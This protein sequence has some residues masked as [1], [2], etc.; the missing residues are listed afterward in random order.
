MRIRVAHISDLHFGK[1]SFSLKHL[2][3]KRWIGMTNLLLSRRKHYLN[4][5]PDTLYEAFEAHGISHV[6]ISGDVSTTSL[7]EEFA[8]ARSFID[9][10]EK[11]GMTV[12]VIPG[13]H[14]HYTRRSF[15]QKLFYDYFPP[16]YGMCDFTLKDHGV[17]W[18][19]LVDSWY[20][21]LMDTAL[22]TPL[23]HSVGFFSKKHEEYLAKV[24][25]TIPKDGHIICVNHFPFF[26]HEPPRRRLK[27]GGDLQAMLRKQEN[28]A[29]YLHGHTHRHTLA[30]VR[31]NGLPLVMDSGSV[32]HK[33]YGTWN[34]LE[35][36]PNQCMLQVY[37]YDKHAPHDWKAIHQKLYSW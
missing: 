3:S 10:L 12:Y 29:M 33:N 23:Y 36:T 28:A 20:V 26:Q 15:R 37:S 8:M 5:R 1:L 21:V 14:D 17:T 30:D 24:F 7:P 11:R 31:A 19:H 35:L 32:S 13:N 4:S 18:F 6:I 2:F 16:T 9:G 34:L 22:A 25:E 27:R